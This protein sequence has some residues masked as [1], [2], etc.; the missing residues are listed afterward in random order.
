LKDSKNLRHGTN[1]EGLE[2]VRDILYKRSFSGTNAP[3][4]LA[5]QYEQLV[6]AHPVLRL[7]GQLFFRTPVRVFE[8]GVRMTPALQILAP[9]F[10]KDLAGKNGTRAQL[11]A[12]GE[13]MMSLGITG[14]VLSLYAQGKITGDGAYTDWRQQRNRTDSDL[15]EPYTIR[16][17]DGS[18]WNYRNFD[19]LATPMKI[20]VNALE[21]YEQ[22]HVRETQG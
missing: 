2:F 9:N 10:I 3:S 8:E 20:M 7:V 16:F 11:K 19:P 5:K 18:T 17:D 21:R 4:K 22:L 12:Q 15:P 1:E 13:A 14:S 6:N